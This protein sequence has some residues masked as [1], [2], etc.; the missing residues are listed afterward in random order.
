[1]IGISI[2]KELITPFFGKKDIILF[3][4][5]Q[6]YYALLLIKRL[7]YIF[8]VYFFIKSYSVFTKLSNDIYSMNIFWE[9]F[10]L[11]DHGFWRH[12]VSRQRGPNKN[13][14]QGFF[15]ATDLNTYSRQQNC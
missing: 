2:M 7:L 6:L 12:T 13:V 3:Q 11:R 14:V 9:K 8:R 4:I 10:F 1:M 15:K 5:F